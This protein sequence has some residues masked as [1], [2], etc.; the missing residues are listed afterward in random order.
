MPAR[1]RLAV[2]STV[3]FPYSH[4]D[5]IVSRWLDPLSTDKAFGW[6]AP[7]HNKPCADIVS[8]YIAQ[9]PENDIGREKAKRYH[10]SLFPTVRGTLTLGGDNLAVDGVLLIGEHGDYPYNELSQQMYPRRELFDEIVAVF[11]A[12]GR[13]VPIFSD[14]HLSYDAVSAKHMVRT[15]R[16]LNFPLMAGSSVS[17]A[18]VIDPWAM[19]ENA[20]LDEAVGIFFGGYESYGYHSIDFLQSLVVRR[21]NGETG[22]ESVTAYY[23]DSFWEAEKAG[24]WAA[25][26]REAALE[27]ARNRAPGHY[28]SNLQ[29]PEP[30]QPFGGKWP[31]AFC[32]THRDGLRSTHLMLDGHVRDWAVA[33]RE[34]SGSVHAGC[35][36]CSITGKA[37]FYAHFAALNAKIEEFMR[38][39]KSPFPVEHYL[40]GTLAIGA[41]VHALAQP[42]EPLATPD[43]ALPYRMVSR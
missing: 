3:Y 40:L 12:T 23:G 1:L 5:V 7:G 28:R 37:S 24:V 38:T 36:R 14:K 16:T 30:P 43:L 31:A 13:S 20:P 17:V 41:A 33:V 32:F 11:R 19:P 10:V 27:Q 21:A 39:G 26:L 18:G 42:G 2:V 22:V 15:A 8:M 6:P 4:S 9:F 29:G 35:S 34:K 25:G